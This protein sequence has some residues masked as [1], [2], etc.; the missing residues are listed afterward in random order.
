MPGYLLWVGVMACS[1][2]N[3]VV[4]FPIRFPIVS[5]LARSQ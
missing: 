2:A 5:E 3:G 4:L 1:M